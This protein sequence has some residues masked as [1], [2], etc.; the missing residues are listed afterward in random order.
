MPTRRYL[1][2]LKHA[3]W[4][5]SFPFDC[6]RYTFLA[7]ALDAVAEDTGRLPRRLYRLLGRTVRDTA[8]LGEDTRTPPEGKTMIVQPIDIHSLRRLIMTRTAPNASQPLPPHCQKAAIAG[9]FLRCG[10]MQDPQSGYHAEFAVKERW[11]ARLVYRLGHLLRLPF[12]VLTRRDRVV[13]YLKDR[14]HLLRLLRRLD[15]HDLVMELQDLVSTRDLLG[16]VNRQ[17]NFET[18]NINKSVAAAEQQ[19]ERIRRLLA[20]PDQ[21]IWSP[22]LRELALLRLRFPH[23]GYEGL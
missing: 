13:F 17:V 16:L 11:R 23:D 6:C 9:L 3:L 12:H 7:L 20:H 8:L 5:A 2:R 19:I 21:G 10:Y 22:A 14:R 15:Q 4:H 1:R 18:A